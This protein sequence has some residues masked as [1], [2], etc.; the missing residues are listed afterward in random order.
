M[1]DLTLGLFFE[2]R[3]G[4]YCAKLSQIQSGWPGQVLAK[5][6]WS[7]SKPMCKNPQSQFWQNATSQRLVSH[8]QTWWHSS[9]DGPDH[10]V[11]N[12]PGSSLVLA[13]CV[14]C[15]PNGSSPE[16][17]QC[18]RIIRPTFGQHFQA[19]LDQIRHVYWAIYS[20]KEEWTS[21]RNSAGAANKEERVN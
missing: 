4:S 15:W 8:S 5:P 1:L 6:I 17:S 10:T 21:N 18:G 9:T 14:R 7:T 2:R 20:L 3:P 19:D 13:D 16:A 12:R 11:Q